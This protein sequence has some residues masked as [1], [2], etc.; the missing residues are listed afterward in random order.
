MNSQSPATKSFTPSAKFNLLHFLA[1]AFARQ[2][3]IDRPTCPSKNHPPES[4]ATGPGAA[5]SY[6]LKRNYSPSHYTSLK[7]LDRE[8][9][10]HN[11]RRQRTFSV[12]RPREIIMARRAMKK[13]VEA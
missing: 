9:R 6:R 8:A 13:M 7:K 4:L 11:G 3:F 10:I 5:F 1:Q 2:T 12:P